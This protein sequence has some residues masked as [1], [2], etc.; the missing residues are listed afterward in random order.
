MFSSDF[1]NSDEESPWGTSLLILV[2]GVSFSFRFHAP[3]SLK[4][5]FRVQSFEHTPKVRRGTLARMDAVAVP[6][7][8]DSLNRLF[9]RVKLPDIEH[10]RECLVLPTLVPLFRPDH[11]WPHPIALF[12]TVEGRVHAS[13]ALA[14][15]LPSAGDDALQS[16]IVHPDRRGGVQWSNQGL[17]VERVASAQGRGRRGRVVVW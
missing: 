17:G 16:V 10:R 15:D 7:S 6:A 3:Q 2:P 4:T 13:V 11:N 12:S 5:V 14:Q 1:V 8:Y 9:H